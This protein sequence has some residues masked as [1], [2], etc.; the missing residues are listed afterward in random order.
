MIAA[1]AALAAWA[2]LLTPDGDA[3][4]PSPPPRKLVAPVEIEFLPAPR[5]KG[6]GRHHHRLRV[7]LTPH[8]DAPRLEVQLTLPQGVALVRG[9]TRWQVPARTRVPQTRELLLKVPP[10]GQRRI[11][12]TARLA[13]PGA[14][15]QTRTAS[16]LYNAARDPA[17]ACGPRNDP[18]PGLPTGERPS[19]VR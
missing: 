4:T 2:V 1:A 5:Q 10:T 3:G 19:D 16:Y 11:V 9:E 7:R 13:P 17:A 15:P 14:L 12:V 8:V 6:N 18:L